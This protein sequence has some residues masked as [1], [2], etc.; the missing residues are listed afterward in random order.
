MLL[1]QIQTMNHTKSRVRLTSFLLLVCTTLIAQT[2]FIYGKIPQAD[3]QMPLADVAV[4][5]DN[6]RTGTSSDKEGNYRIAVKSNRVNLTFHCVGCKTETFKA[7]IAQGVEFQHDVVMSS[8]T[9]KLNEVTVVGRNEVRR[10]RESA[11]PVSVMTFK[12]LQGTASSIDEVLA[13][14]AGITV[15]STGGVGSASR[16]SV[17][18]LEG[19][20]LG[21]FVDETSMGQLTNFVT[22]NDIPTDMIERIEVY[23]GIVPYKFGG[24]ALGGAVNVVTKEYPPMYLDASYECGSFNTHRANAVLKRTNQRLGL[25]F[26][27]GG[28]FTYSDNSYL[29]TLHNLD[30]RRVRRNHDAYRKA[31][32]GG[33]LKATKWWFDE[34]KLEALY[35]NTRQEIQGIDTDIREAFNHSSG[36]A[37]ELTLK[38]EQFFADALAF[39]FNLAYSYAGYGLSDKAMKRYDW[40]GTAYPPT[41]PYGGEQGAYPA[42]GH[43]RSHDLIS[44]LNLNYTLDAHHSFNL[45][46]YEAYTRLL[47]KDELMEKALGFKANF[48]SRMN[49]VTTGLSYD[50]ML[51][52]NR[53]QSAFTVKDYFFTSK[54]RYLPNFYMS[55]AENINLHRHYIGWNESMRYRLTHHLMVKASFSSEV[56]TP[57]SEELIGNGYSVLAST[58]LQPERVKSMN[59]GTLYRR[60]HEQNGLLEAELNLFYSRL[61]DMI[62][63][64]PD[65][66]PAFYHY[67]NFGEVRT[68]GIEVDVKYDILPWLYAYANCTYQDLR[69]VRRWMP[70]SNVE[71]PTYKKR[72]PNIPYLLGNGGVECH[73]E[74]LFGVKGSNTRLLLD[75]SYIHQYFYDFEM[76]V[77]QDRKIPT[78]F[79]LDAGL[80]HSMMNNRWTFSLKVKNLTNR[81][82]VSE[83]NRPLP[84]RSFAI[85]VRYL[86]K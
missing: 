45:N 47:P 6:G 24:S 74:N 52:D 66:V 12:E 2:A 53:F 79:T 16:L 15:R 14:S 35:S 75:V 7:T 85:K 49:S 63:Y 71:N 9:V 34:L 22:L 42:D 86:L 18:G 8:T 36:F 70:E 68:Y 60:F 57:T 55:N 58:H 82:V 44:K 19:K 25:Q 17:R 26:G 23:K 11:M 3:T 10:M 33:S 77:N 65:V 30:G 62:R 37:T 27:V 32:F 72:I 43:N 41:S 67:T 83:L 1:D 29:M 78:S 84:G 51:F 61:K 5:A 50:L 20:R 56:R 38:R 48:N 81:D 28:L 13:R 39:D 4:S 76:S 46:V 21:L 54:T 73:R 40:D 64:A 80:E 31:V 59:L 69:D